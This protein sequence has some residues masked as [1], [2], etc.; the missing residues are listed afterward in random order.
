VRVPVELYER[1]MRLVQTFE[2]RT[3]TE[4]VIDSLR[5]YC[6][7]LERNEGSLRPRYEWLLDAASGNQRSDS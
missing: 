2:Y 4:F 1:M 6:S 3:L 5:L 7:L